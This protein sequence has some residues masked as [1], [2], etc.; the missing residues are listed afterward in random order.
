M[1]VVKYKYYITYSYIS[2]VAT[3]EV[4]P[5]GVDKL[6]I[7]YKGS[8]G[9]IFKRRFLNGSLVFIDQPLVPSTDYTLFKNIDASPYDKCTE[10]SFEIK[11]SCDNGV[12]YVDDFWNGYFSVTDGTFDLDRCTFT[13]DCQPDDEYRCFVENMEQ[14]FPLTNV[15]DTSDATVSIIPQYEFFTCNDIAANCNA[16][17]PS[18]TTGWTIF[19]QEVCE[20]SN[21]TIYYRESTIVACQGGVPVPPYGWTTLD[22]SY[23]N[24]TYGLAKYVRTPVTI[25]ANNPNPYVFAGNCRTGDTPPPKEIYLGVV[26]SASATTPIIVGKNNVQVTANTTEYYYVKYPKANAT[27]VWG[28]TGGG[29]TITSGGTTSAVVVDI[30]AAGSVTVIET[31][32]CGASATISQ[33]FTISGGSGSSTYNA[34]V[35][36]IGNEE[37]CVGETATYYLNAETG[38]TPS[39]FGGT[40]TGTLTYLGN[41]IFTVE[42]LTAG[43]I[44]IIW[45]GGGARD[46][47][48]TP[49]MTITVKVK[50]SIQAIYG[51]ASVCNNSQAYY[52]I[53]DTNLGGFV[54]DITGGGTILSGQGTNEILVQWDGNDGIGF[55]YVSQDFNCGCNWQQIAECIPGF[56]SWWWCP[57]TSDYT[58]PGN[59]RLYST[60]DYMN[61]QLCPT[62]GPLVSDF[63]GW[64]PAGDT[65]GYVAGTNYVTGLQNKLT[66]MSILPLRAVVYGFTGSGAFLN[67]DT[68]EVL[69]WKNIEEILREV[70]NS[71]WFIENGVLRIEHISWF[72]RTVTY[73]LTDAYYNK[74]LVGKNVY[75][76]NKIKAPQYERFKFDNSTYLDFV[77]AEISYTGTCTTNEDSQKVANRGVSYVSTDLTNILVL[78]TNAGRDGF[79]LLATDS[80]SVIQSDIGKLSEVNQPNGHLSWAN[81]HYNYH[82]YD[83]VLMNGM[84]NLQSTIFLSARRY[85]T[86]EDVSFPF[87]CVDV[88]N[89]LTDLITTLVGDGVIDE[90]EHDLKTDTITVTL[91]HDF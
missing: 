37:L 48:T 80:N 63:F 24:C 61:E 56:C 82:R 55:V 16:L 23:P 19:H 6:Q 2:T 50:K 85:K 78:G 9:Q 71:Y 84:M 3:I 1:N 62:M 90:A 67:I 53:P 8:E 88:I 30:V 15:A 20:G 29:N 13:V 57:D 4:H 51:D 60:I 36:I 40:G 22:T 74:Y 77:G 10:I 76:Y 69:T 81:L 44:G 89:P 75:S 42:A 47:S 64:N 38:R 33:A 58:I 68:D 28:I 41:S 73:D 91:L 52:L 14:E 18:P 66:N 31:T 45:S 87:C 11:R 17:R 34:Q 26:K 54:W 59:H 5:L 83:R 27:Y 49:T 86:Q 79:V 35:E 39:I 12:T 21:V 25:Y 46:S 72:N 70:F 7:Q 32:T 43:T 65:S